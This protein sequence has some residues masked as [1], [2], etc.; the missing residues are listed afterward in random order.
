MIR[1]VPT[2]DLPTTEWDRQKMG[3]VDFFKYVFGAVFFGSPST[4]ETGGNTKHNQ[5]ENGTLEYV[6]TLV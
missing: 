3:H 6:E 4:Y 2:S 5:G 1:S